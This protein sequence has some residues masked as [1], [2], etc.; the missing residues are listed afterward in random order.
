VILKSNKP[1]IVGQNSNVIMRVG[2]I[3]ARVTSKQAAGHPEMNKQQLKAY[4]QGHILAQSA[5]GLDPAPH[6]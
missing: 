2:D 1:A 4:T 5:Y 6:N 3:R